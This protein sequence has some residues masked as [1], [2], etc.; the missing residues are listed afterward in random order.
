MSEKKPDFNFFISYTYRK[1][2]GIL[3]TGCISGTAEGMKALYLCE[4][5]EIVEF[6]K[7]QMPKKYH[8]EMVI[9]YWKE[10]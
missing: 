6:V 8:R 2:F 5:D 9:M 4:L 10:W 3:G 7:S 1:R